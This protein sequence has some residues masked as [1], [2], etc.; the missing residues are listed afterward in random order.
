MVTEYGMSNLGPVQFEQQSEGSVFLGRDY[1]KSR[2]FSGQI[3]FQ[4]DEEVRSIINEQYKVT[5]KIIK[6][7]M[8]LLD[9]IAKTLIEK[10]TLTKEEIDSLV[11]N[12]SLPNDDSE[13]SFEDMTVAELKKL[14]TEANNAGTGFEKLQSRVQNMSTRIQG[15]FG[16]I[17]NAFSSFTLGSMISRSIY[18]AVNEDA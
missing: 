15:F 13:I 11:E 1:N 16:S 7:N 12:G 9:L 2:N 17:K 10:E 3:A 6:E 4:I 14:D 18:S 8:D 5:E